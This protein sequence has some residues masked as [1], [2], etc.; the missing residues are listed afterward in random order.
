MPS[1]APPLYR[2]RSAFAPSSL[3]GETFGVLINL[4]GR[5]RFTSQR[6]VLYAVLASL[7]HEAAVD[8]ACEALRQFSDAHTALVKGSD[9]LP[10]VFCEELEQAYFGSAQGERQIREFMAL[11]ERALAA[12]QAASSQ[13][14]GLL[15]QLVRSATP[16]LAVLNGITQVYEELARRHARQVKK[17]LHGIMTDIESIAK[18]ARMVSF[19]AQIVAARAGMAGREFSVVASELSNITGEIDILVR[20]ALHDSSA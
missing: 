16:M 15:D 1:T 7:G 8:T 14:P 3:S 20:Q 17:Q 18:Q 19:N 10:G 4:S 13:A 12:L 11:A 9:E 6:L 2:H 5:R